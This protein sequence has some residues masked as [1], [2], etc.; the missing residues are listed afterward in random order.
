MQQH[1][2]DFVNNPGCFQKLYEDNKEQREVNRDVVKVDSGEG[3][4][5]NEIFKIEREIIFEEKKKSENNSKDNNISNAKIDFNMLMHGDANRNDYKLNKSFFDKEFDNKESNKKL[6]K[7]ITFKKENIIQTLKDIDIDSESEDDYQFNLKISSFEDQSTIKIN[8]KKIKN[9]KQI[10]SKNLKISKDIFEE[11][12]GNEEN[13]I[14]DEESFIKEYS[15]VI[16]KHEHEKTFPE[17][18]NPSKNKIKSEFEA[19]FEQFYKNNINE[20]D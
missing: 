14:L 15:K 1:Y 20:N 12:K 7:I 10:K 9:K 16:S 3:K 2:N 5:K 8:T 6:N 17:E 4:N 18:F 11:I 19:N 13:R